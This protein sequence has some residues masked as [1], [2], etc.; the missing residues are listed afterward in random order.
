[1]AQKNIW[2]CM[3]IALCVCVWRRDVDSETEKGSRK[4]QISQN[5]NSEFRWNINIWIL[6]EVL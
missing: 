3:Y 2:L 6:I 4:A 1:M 5:V